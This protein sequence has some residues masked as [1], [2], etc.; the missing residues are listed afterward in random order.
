MTAPLSF[1]ITTRIVSHQICAIKVTEISTSIST[2]SISNWYFKIVF[3]RVLN[4]RKQIIYCKT[5]RWSHAFVPS[6]KSRV[7][8]MVKLER[9]SCKLDL[10]ALHDCKATL[11]F[12]AS[13]YLLMT[14]LV[15]HSLFLTKKCN[16]TCFKQNYVRRQMLD[17]HG[18]GHH[19]QLR[20]QG[21]RLHFFLWCSTQSNR[22][23][24][25]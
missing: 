21:T 16:Q 2:S 17:S 23:P 10:D 5:S 11:T 22:P 4:L 20:V 14:S 18:T 12:D 7:H 24:F 15:Q 9:T 1:H 19:H 13:C 6:S 3:L 8:N 25:F